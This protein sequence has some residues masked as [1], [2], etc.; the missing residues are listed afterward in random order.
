MRLPCKVFPVQD[1]SHIYSARLTVSIGL[2]HTHAPR[3]KRFEA[4][5]DSGAS[6]CM[7]NADIG[8][9]IG[10]DIE[11]GRLEQTV[12]ISSLS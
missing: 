9:F 10:L 8:R 3:T 5:I 11:A 2:P 6:R 7:F 1:G 4:V 12:G